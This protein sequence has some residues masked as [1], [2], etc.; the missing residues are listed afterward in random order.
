MIGAAYAREMARYNAWMNDRLFTRLAA[1]PR[2]AIAT[3]AGIFFGSIERT[4][5]HIIHRDQRWLSWFL[6]EPFVANRPAESFY[7]DF[8]SLRRARP[9]VDARISAWANDVTDVWFNGELVR[10]GGSGDAPQT[11][12]RSRWVVQMFN[13]QTHHRSQVI[14]A[15]T[16]Q[17][18]DMG[19]TDFAQMPRG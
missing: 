2:G 9:N 11:A 18:V 8:D 4:L 6:D 15:L 12:P 19:V 16:Q 7:P 1:L 3:D 17:G 10:P 5:N 13:H 14:T